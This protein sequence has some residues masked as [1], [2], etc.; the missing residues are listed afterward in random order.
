MPGRDEAAFRAPMTDAKTASETPP[1]TR[2]G[3]A[4]V[5][6]P[7]QRIAM[8]HRSDPNP[9][10]FGDLP[11]EVGRELARLDTLARLLDA[12]F[13]IPIINI[14]FGY[15]AILGLVPGLGDA[16]AAGPSAWLIYRAHRL[17]MPRRTLV[18]MAANTGIDFALGSVPLFG[19]LF[20]LVF[21]ANLRNIALLRRH[22]ERDR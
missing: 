3:K 15:D 18:R 7:S 2:Q 21:K 22:L 19:N 14:P 17:G 1:M 5:G 4:G 12:K 16:V 8:R 10:P 9:S 20:D 6:P 11:P 13:T